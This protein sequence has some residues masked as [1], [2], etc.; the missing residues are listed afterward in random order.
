MKRRGILLFA[1]LLV[2]FV[3]SITLAGGEVLY[4][5]GFEDVAE[6]KRPTGWGGSGVISL[7]QA[8]VGQKSF[9]MEDN[10]ETRYA[11]AISPMTPVSPNSTYTAAIWAMTDDL[12][13]DGGK[14]AVLIE[15]YSGGSRVATAWINFP[16]DRPLD[17]TLS[18]L[19]FT[20]SPTTNTIR[21]RLYPAGLAGATKKGRAWFDD[22]YLMEGEEFTPPKPK[23]DKALVFP[24]PFS[25]EIR[26]SY[27]IE[28]EGAQ[29]LFSVYNEAGT[30]V[31]SKTE[32]VDSQGA[33]E[34]E[35]DGRDLGGAV[36][37]PGLY[38]CLVTLTCDNGS[39]SQLWAIAVKAK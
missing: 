8:K 25:D 34:V 23:Q 1:L 38:K 27:S 9:F 28:A 18:T 17:W 7:A 15:E 10:D 20:T 16:M 5:E 33:H 30:Q 22:L 39:V 3:N 19:T 36:A 29:V 4:Y 31:Y 35:W 37:P 6:G 26:L 2:L 21:F 24:N 12:V 32:R 14:I 13:G 11:E